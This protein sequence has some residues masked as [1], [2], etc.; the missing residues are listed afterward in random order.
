MEEIFSMIRNRLEKKGLDKHLGGGVVIT[1]G[2]AQLPGTAELAREVFEIPAR[3]GFPV[4][5]GGLS[6][7]FQSPVYSTGVGLVLYAAEI[8]EAE[9]GHSLPTKRSGD[10]MM[11]K[12][13]NWF[14]E[15]L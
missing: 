14:K 15:F 8:V 2:G 12:L 3:I 6:D 4:K 5:V 7:V 11:G 9:S 10:G 1:G 13:K